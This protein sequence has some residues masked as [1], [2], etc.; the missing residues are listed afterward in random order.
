M[1]KLVH[2]IGEFL[3]T[4]STTWVEVVRHFELAGMWY[5]NAGQGL[6]D[7]ANMLKEFV[8]P[9]KDTLPFLILNSCDRQLQRARSHLGVRVDHMRRTGASTS[10]RCADHVAVL[11]LQF[12]RHIA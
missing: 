9:N 7:P 4:E 8:M 5:V 12:G 6:V 11:M 3:S 1:P 2:E 10:T